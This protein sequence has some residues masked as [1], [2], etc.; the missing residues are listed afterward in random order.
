MFLGAH[1]TGRECAE[2]YGCACAGDGC[3]D[4][5]PSVADCESAHAACDAA[6]CRATY[7]EW[8]PA[9]AG[10][11]GFACGG[12]LDATCEM[13]VE[14][15]LCPLGESFTSGVGC[16]FDSTC[17]DRDL[18]QASRGIWHAASECF[19]GF[20]CGQPNACDGCVDSCD[21]GAHR[22]FATGLGCLPS[23]SCGSVSDEE[24]CGATG[25]FWN[26]CSAGL[27]GCGHFECGRPNLLDPCIAPGC[28]CGWTSNFD[29]IE[30]CVLDDRCF[31]RQLDQSCSG[32]GMEWTTCRPGL[33]CCEHCG[34]G[35]GC[36]S[37][38]SPCCPSDSFCEEQTGCYP[39]PP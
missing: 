33:A 39:P 28:D 35:P 32:Y 23:A 4:L 15:C 20:T 27:C 24:L 5:F 14:A 25:G 21:C 13:P 18:C 38:Q 7:G 12:P 9:A 11:C 10:F 34:V 3:A 6:R 16:A 1:W 36:A 8:F 26:D 31:Y 2:L 22:N 37:C 17:T 19:C 30:G 29:P